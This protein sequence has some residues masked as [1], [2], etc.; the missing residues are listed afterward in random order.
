VNNQKK[1]KPLLEFIG[2]RQSLT[3]AELSSKFMFPS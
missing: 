1:L 3:K 2:L